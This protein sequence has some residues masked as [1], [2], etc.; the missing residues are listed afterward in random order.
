[1]IKWC[2]VNLYRCA[3]IISSQSSFRSSQ[4]TRKF[5]HAHLWFIFTPSLG[6]KQPLI[7]FLT[8]QFCLFLEISY[9]WNHSTCNFFIC[10]FSLNNVSEVYHTVVGISNSFM[11][12]NGLVHCMDTTHFVYPFTSWWTL[13]LLLAFGY[14]EENYCDHSCTNLY[15]GICFISCVHELAIHTSL[16]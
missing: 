14:Y 13:R 1:M 15:V 10:L 8:L 12:M 16:W 3:A 2:L 5:S 6:P 4:H 11:L 9:K 7:C